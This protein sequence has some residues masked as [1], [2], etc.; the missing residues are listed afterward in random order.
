MRK[1]EFDFST[2]RKVVQAEPPFCPTCGQRLDGSTGGEN[3][4][5][6]GSLGICMYCGEINRFTKVP[7]G[8]AMVAI[9]HLE[10]QG[11]PVEAQIKLK[12]LQAGIRALNKS[13]KP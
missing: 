2:R 10:F 13:R 6:P 3:A 7:G 4:P 9:T 12:V 8:L 5:R 11:L 1:I